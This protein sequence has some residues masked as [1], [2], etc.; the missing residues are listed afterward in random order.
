MSEGKQDSKKEEVPPSLSAPTTTTTPQVQPQQL[1]PEGWE[2]HRH[3]EKGVSYYYN[4]AS[5]KSFLRIIL[6][7]NHK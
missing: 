1:L 2:E 3:D 6:S 5:G 4:V 7:Q